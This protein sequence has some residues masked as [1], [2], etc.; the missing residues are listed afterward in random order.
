M[1]YMIHRSFLMAV[2]T[3]MS[4]ALAAGLCLQ[5]A[6]AA[7]LLYDGFDYPVGEELG[8]R[9]SA[10]IWDNDKNQFTIV[11]GSLSYAGLKASTGHRLNVAAVAPSL[12]SVRTLDGSWPKQSK[13]IL[14]VSFVLRLQSVAEIGAAGEGTS[15]V[16]IGD[17]FNYAELLGINLRMD[18]GVR[19]GV[20]KYSANSA[21]VS[22]SAFF[23]SGSGADLAVDGATTYL[24]VAKYEWAEGADND[25]VTL[26]VNPANLGTTE[27]PANKVFT[28]AGP[29]GAASAGR[30]TLSRGPNVNIDEVRIG[31]TWADVTPPGESPQ[32][33]LMLVGVLA[34]GLVGAGLWITKLR[35][36]VNE[37]SAALGAQIQERQKAE[38]QR[39]ME[40]ERARIAHDLH[41]ELGADI[42]E[43]GMLATRVQTDAGGTEERNRCLK[44]MVDKT[45]QMVAK[46]EEIVW[47]MNPQHDSLGALVSYFTFLADRLLGL[48]NIK[49]VVDTSED[50]TSLALEA[51]RRH[52]LFLVFKEA[53]ANVI[54]HSGASEV[55]LSVRV[56]NRIL[57]VIVTDNG[58]GL[59]ELSPTAGGHEGIANMRR[60]ME[61]LGGEFEITGEPDRGTTVKFSV[62][63]ES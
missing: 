43:I 51:R 50:A 39:L 48:A 2:A 62:S 23:T 45:R 44:Q 19:I 42:T 40:Q 8:E 21:A 49:L 30:L 6:P 16:T 58:C 28:S 57:H 20:I 3:R 63:L 35:R 18:D 47:A 27:D 46:L 15:L 36:K 61:K 13:G 59:C 25:V 41:D 33:L 11:R 26:W 9:S 17:T 60:R 24:I 1:N 22:S 34:C 52:Q 38:Q 55:R 29:D 37:R 14:Y 31:K 10:T 12:D 4:L 7:P 53:L 32:R 56:E 5:D 54:R